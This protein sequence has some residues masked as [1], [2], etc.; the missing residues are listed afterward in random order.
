MPGYVAKA[1][2]RF[3]HPEP[4]R[5]QHSPHAWLKP[6]Y[7]VP[8]QLTPEPDDSAPL[9]KAAITR[10]QEVIG[11]LLYYARAIDSTMLVALGSL[12]SAQ[13]H[14]TE[15]TAKACTHLLNYC[16]THPDAVIRYHASG[17][18]LHLHSDA[19]YLSEPKAR[20]QAG[21]I[22]FLSSPLS[23][24]TQAPAP[25]DTPPPSNGALHIL[26]SIMPMVLS[27][28]TE[29]ELGALFYNAKEACMLRT[30]LS[31]MGHPQPATPIQ[32][33]NAVASGIAN[34]KVKQRRSKAIDMRFYWIK[35]RVKNGEFLIH[36]RKGIDNDADYFTK[37]HSPSHHRLL[38]SRY[39]QTSS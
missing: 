9:D 15:A 36:W 25:T 4:T 18:V 17:M 29:A 22:F 39:L 2:Q 33:D 1:L 8:T 27:S 7:G 28:A 14:G 31:E 37:H 13:T 20:S 35:D 26:S 38:R 21:G 32:T 3:Q 24:P 12:A 34:D 19:S 23:D 6:N 16:A 30:T 5:A 10:L 11:T